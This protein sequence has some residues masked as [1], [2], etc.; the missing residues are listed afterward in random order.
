MIKDDQLK[1]ALL[2]GN[3]IGEGYLQG[4]LI[5]KGYLWRVL[6]G[7]ADQ[8]EELSEAPSEVP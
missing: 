4:V 7:G 1:T 3:L 8:S 2:M 6:T 5:G